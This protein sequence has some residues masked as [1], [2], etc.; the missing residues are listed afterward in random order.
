MS[1]SCPICKEVI[2]SKRLG[3]AV[4]NHYVREIARKFL[5]EGYFVIQEG[6]IPIMTKDHTT[7]LVDRVKDIEVEYHSQHWQNVVRLWREPDLITLKKSKTSNLYKI[8]KA[9]E[10]LGTA[11]DFRILAAKVIKIKQFI[12]PNQI[13]VFDAIRFVD[14]WLDE[15][16][17]CK[18][19]RI[20]TIEPSSYKQVDLHYKQIISQKLNIDFEMWFEENLTH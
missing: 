3:I 5:D 13:I 9:I 19:K 17:K 7:D 10:V 14:R 15:K 18:L 4:H 16:R 6:Q 20:M 1:Y 12:K 11:E 2:T 8:D